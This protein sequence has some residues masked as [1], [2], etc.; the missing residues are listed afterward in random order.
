MADRTKIE[1]P[2]EP[3]ATAAAAAKMPAACL[4][5]AMEP[6]L[7]LLKGLVTTLRYLGERSSSDMIEPTAI[8]AISIPAEE[9]IDRMIALGRD[10]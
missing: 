8:A 2:A 1:Q 10:R 5:V 7:R 3:S 9:A 4:I 6:D